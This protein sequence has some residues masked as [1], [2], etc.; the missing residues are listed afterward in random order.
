[1]AR[2]R[3]W[4]PIDKTCKACGKVFH[5]ETHYQVK[6]QEFCSKACRTKVHGNGRKVQLIDRKCKVCGKDLVVRPCH[7][8]TKWFCSYACSNSFNRSGANNPQWKGGDRLGK[9]WKR[10]ARIRDDFTCQIPECGKRVVGAGTHAHHK[11]P[12]KAGGTNDLDNLTTLC[13]KHHHEMER[14]L[15][16]AL[17]ESHPESAKAIATGLFSW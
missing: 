7:K 8:D 6:K 17:V 1:M 12:R 16:Q 2:P 13:S 15:L 3:T 4:N 9:Y 14:R 5:A 10:Q 11:I